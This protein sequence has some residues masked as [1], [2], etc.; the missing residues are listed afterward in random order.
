MRGKSEKGSITIFVLVA[1]LFYVSVLLLLYAGNAAKMQSI[2][3]KAESVKAIYEKNINKEDEL[4]NKRLA[5][6][7]ENENTTPTQEP[8]EPTEGI[9]ALKK[10]LLGPQLQGRP[11]TEIMN[12]NGTAF[13]DKDGEGSI[14]RASTKVKFLNEYYYQY[15]DTTDNGTVMAVYVK[16]NNVAYKVMTKGTTYT[17]D[18]T[19]G[20]QEVYKPKAGSKEGT[21]V[22]YSADGS[23]TKTDWLVLY[24]NGSTLD[25]MSVDTMGNLTLGV[26]DVATAGSTDLEKAIYSYNNAVS[27]L[28]NYCNTLVTNSTAQ[29]VR[30]VGAK[31]DV[32]DTLETYSSDKT[33]NWQTT[34]NGRGKLGDTNAE[35]DIIRMSFYDKA[36][37]SYG[38]AKSNA[39]YWLASRFVYEYSSGVRFRVWYVFSGGYASGYS[40]LWNVDSSYADGWSYSYAVRPVVRVATNAVS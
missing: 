8:E 32:T 27:R 17:T 33:S 16:Y 23:G 28:N 5:K 3:K 6:G 35:E 19:K 29:K 10:Y 14:E 22:K 15:D 20:V 40:S 7:G 4:Y 12:E 1:L 2:T 9:E 34:Y 11:I 21:I 39:A 38:Y 26:K 24:D 37:S 31:F 18:P 25:I 30:S 36:D 13:I